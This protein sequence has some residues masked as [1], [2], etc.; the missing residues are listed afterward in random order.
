MFRAYRT[1][2]MK[3]FCVLGRT[4]PVEI[5]AAQ[6]TATYCTYNALKKEH[7]NEKKSE[8]SKRLDDLGFY[9]G[10]TDLQ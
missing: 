5:T 10:K 8:P 4:L 2:S 7:T 1:V 6:H 9:N 3:V